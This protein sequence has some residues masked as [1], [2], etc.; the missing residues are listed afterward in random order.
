MHRFGFGSGEPVLLQPGEHLVTAPLEADG[1]TTTLG[2]ATCYDLRFPEMFRGLLDAGAEVLV[3]PAA[4]PARR[5]GHW[6]L[7][8]RARAIEN[9]QVLVAVNTVGTHAGHAMGG[10]SQVVGPMG[11]VL[12]EAGTD[13]QVL[14]VD[15]DLEMVAAA[16]KSFP[17]LDDRRL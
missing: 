7:L 16:R 17:V 6:T 4:W 9:Q 14:V 11:E 15:V 2:L 5:V 1:R 8:G 10:H 3:V 13:E 12:G